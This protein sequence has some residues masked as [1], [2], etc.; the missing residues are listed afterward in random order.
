MQEVESAMGVFQSLQRDPV[1]SARPF[2]TPRAMGQRD[3]RRDRKAEELPLGGATPDP[4]HPRIQE[5]NDGPQHVIRCEGVAAM[6]PERTPT[7]AEHDSA[8]GVRE[9]LVD[10]SQPQLPEPGGEPILEQ[11]TL[12]RC[13]SPWSPPATDTATFGA[14]LLAKENLSDGMNCRS[15]ETQRKCWMWTELSST[16]TRLNTEGRPPRCR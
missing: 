4:W 5:L 2:V 8:V 6:Q 7:Q 9:H 13:H 15:A 14:P 11:E 1:L 12:L 3:V 16:T 10:F